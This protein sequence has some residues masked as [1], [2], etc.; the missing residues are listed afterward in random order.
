MKLSVRL[1]T[2]E[3]ARVAHEINRAY[4]ASI[5]DHSQPAWDDAPQWQKESAIAG[6][7]FHLAHPEATPENSHKSWLAQ[8]RADGWKYGPV[9]DP[10]KK[11]HPCFV[12]Y[13]DL[14]VEQ[15]SKDYIFRAVIHALNVG[16]D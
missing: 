15:R 13:L 9:K 6:A 16:K 14:P 12:P 7:D 1:A 4:C 11:E 10:E 8:K 2:V 3:I 5:G